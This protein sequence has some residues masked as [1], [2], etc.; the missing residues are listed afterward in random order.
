MRCF[1]RGLVQSRNE[2]EMSAE[3][4]PVLR[5]G[6][7]IHQHSRMYIVP[8]SFYKEKRTLF[9]FYDLDYLEADGHFILRIISTNAR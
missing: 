1:S 5:D 2:A 3:D 7:E 9:H 4:L 8:R 6:Q